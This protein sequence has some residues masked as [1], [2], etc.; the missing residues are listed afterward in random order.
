MTLEYCYKGFFYSEIANNFPMTPLEF[1]QWLPLFSSLFIHFEL[2][3]IGLFCR[4]KMS[5]TDPTSFLFFWGLWMYMWGMHVH[6]YALHDFM[7]VQLQLGIA[8]GYSCLWRLNL[9][10]GIFLHPAYW[11]SVSWWTWGSLTAAGLASQIAWGTRVSASLVWGLQVQA[12]STWLI[13]VFLGQ[14]SSPHTGTTST[15]VTESSS[16]LNYF[17]KLPLHSMKWKHVSVENR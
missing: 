7:H 16:V 12:I 3:F 17:S 5:D 10:A 15:L 8:N 1:L 14:N 13:L 6:T 2:L 4:C 9:M 11:D